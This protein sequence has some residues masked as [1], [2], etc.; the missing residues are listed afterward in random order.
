MQKSSSRLSSDHPRAAAINALTTAPAVSA[1]SAVRCSAS[2]RRCSTSSLNALAWEAL[3]GVGAAGRPGERRPE[4]DF[5]LTL[6]RHGHAAA[7]YRGRA[8][9]PAQ[10]PTTDPGRAC[11][12]GHLTDLIRQGRQERGSYSATYGPPETRTQT[13][14]ETWRQ[15]RDGR[16]PGARFARRCE[17]GAGLWLVDLNTTNGLAEAD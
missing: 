14:P 10:G 15:T 8:A 6:T 3:L 13:R 16:C 2:L 9:T 17:P 7:S 1:A 11:T 5:F 4:G 12:G